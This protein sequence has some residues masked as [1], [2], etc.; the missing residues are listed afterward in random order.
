MIHMG[1]MCVLYIRYIYHTLD[2]IQYTQVLIILLNLFVL[3]LLVNDF[4]HATIE[5]KLL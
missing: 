3:S 4:L 2:L 5:T 1:H